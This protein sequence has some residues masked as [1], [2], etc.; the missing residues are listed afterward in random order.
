MK[1][2]ML[3][4]AAAMVIA[5]GAG[6]MAADL[7]TYESSGFPISPVQVQLLGAKNVQEQPVVAMATVNGMAASPHQISVLKPRTKRTAAA[8]ATDVTTTGS[9]AR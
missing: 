6:A 1:V 4:A 3:I 9:V 7:P 5:G 2:V 8:I